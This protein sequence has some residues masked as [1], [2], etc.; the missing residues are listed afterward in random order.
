MYLKEETVKNLESVL[1][2][3]LNEIRNMDLGDEIAY[4]E[5]KNM[6]KLRFPEHVDWR[7]TSTGEPLIAMGRCRTMEDVDE[8]FDKLLF[9]RSLL[10][11]I[12]KL[13]C[14]KEK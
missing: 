10:W 7:F 14:R 11:E 3:P 6:E 12:K 1:G 5:R 9:P 4:V 13:F 2:K 8:Y